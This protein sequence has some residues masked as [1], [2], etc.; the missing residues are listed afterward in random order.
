MISRLYSVGKVTWIG[1]MFLGC[2]FKIF[3]ISRVLAID[4]LACSEKYFLKVFL[5]WI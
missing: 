1:R 5:C 4:G 2:K 3:K